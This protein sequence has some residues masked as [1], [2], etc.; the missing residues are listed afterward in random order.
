VEY[1]NQA[2]AA[3]RSFKIG[4]YG[5]K[6]SAL[7][8]FASFITP[9]LFVT[10]ATAGCYLQQRNRNV[11]ISNFIGQMSEWYPVSIYGKFAQMTNIEND[12][13]V[14]YGCVCLS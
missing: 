1:L 11:K 7:E 9:C 13:W 3:V 4:L 5:G 8:K 2:I 12:G 10:M 6:V 14:Q